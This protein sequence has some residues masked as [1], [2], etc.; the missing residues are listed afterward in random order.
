MATKEALKRA[1]DKYKKK[2]LYR[3]VNF[4]FHRIS[5]ADILDYIDS[6]D[7]KTGKI[8]ELLREDMRRSKQ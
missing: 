4:T 6:L 1:R 7:N 8:K 5:D 3:N 2:G